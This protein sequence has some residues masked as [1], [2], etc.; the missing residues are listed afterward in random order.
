MSN[1]VCG[2]TKTTARPREV[3]VPAEACRVMTPDD[4][5]SAVARLLGDDGKA[6]WLEPSH[7]DGAFLMALREMRVPARRVWAVDLHTKRHPNDSMA[8]VSRGVDFLARHWVDPSRFDRIIGNPPYIAIEKLR[9]PLRQVAANTRDPYGHAIGARANT[10]YAFMLRCV[11]LLATG[12]RMGMVLP[13]SSEYAS[14]AS[15]G[16][17]CLADHFDRVDLFRFAMPPFPDAQ[18]GNIVLIAKGYRRSGKRSSGTL[19]RSTVKS[20][21]DLLAQSR[22]RKASSR[23]HCN[24]PRRLNQNERCVGEL[25]A[26]RIGAVTG[27][28]KYFLM[29]ESRRRELGLPIRA[30]RFAL[31]KSKHASRPFVSRKDLQAMRDADDRVLLFRPPDGVLSHDRVDAYLRLPHRYGGCAKRNLKVASRSL[32]HRT[33]L[34]AIPD[35][36][37]SGMTSGELMI[38]INKCPGLTATNTLF[39]IHKLCEFE[40]LDLAVGILASKARRQIARKRRWYPSG[41][42]KIEPTELSSVRIPWPIRHAS[43]QGYSNAC[44]LLQ[45]GSYK[46][47]DG[48]I[49]DMI[50]H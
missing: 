49:W 50:G 29:T 7:G 10:W 26:V 9:D 11:Q 21:D 45:S 15:Q 19:R 40:M 20:V 47:A 44:E 27:D 32:W 6:R 24:R 34:P 42:M 28:A 30:F 18:D 23:P 39:V 16:R 43:R 38:S 36:F 14:Y 1:S 48:L 2:G 4:L 5:A 33:P 31:T 37:V 25:A 46:E 35:G 41:L 22:A 8:Q 13:A 17:R 12:G 3:P